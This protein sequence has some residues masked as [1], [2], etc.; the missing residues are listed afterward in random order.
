MIFVDLFFSQITYKILFVRY[1][2]MGI[3]L[4][5]RGHLDNNYAYIS[6][7][8]RA[9]KLISQVFMQNA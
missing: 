3:F 9:T 8:F 5:S 7:F 1:D 6:L 4:F 2:L